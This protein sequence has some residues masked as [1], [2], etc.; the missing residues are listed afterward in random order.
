MP[1]PSFSDRRSLAKGTLPDGTVGEEL[2]FFPSFA[3][4]L[5]NLLWCN[6]AFAK[7]CLD[8][9]QGLRFHTGAVDSHTVQQVFGTGLVSILLHA[10][11]VE[12]Q[13]RVLQRQMLISFS[14]MSIW[15]M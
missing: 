7:L 15:P 1:A 5:S 6:A 9:V 4:V 12:K 8:D 3:F 2:G 10:L 13:V 11:D 14:K